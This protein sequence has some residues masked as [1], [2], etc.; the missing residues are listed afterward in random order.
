MNQWQLQELLVKILYSSDQDDIQSLIF[1]NSALWYEIPHP[2][3]QMVLNV[4]LQMFFKSKVY[5]LWNFQK[6]LAW[7][8]DLESSSL[9]ASAVF[10]AVVFL[11]G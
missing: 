9:L 3:P 11:A 6:P 2:Q 4:F 10:F 1:R 7:C 5:L 8:G